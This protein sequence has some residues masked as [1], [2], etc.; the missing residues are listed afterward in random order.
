MIASC[1]FGVEVQ[2]AR[3][4][5]ACCLWRLAT[6]D[7]RQLQADAVISAIGMFN[8]IAVPD[9]EGLETFRGALFHTARWRDDHDL[10]GERV[11]IIG[12]AASAVQTIPEIAPVVARLD[13][14]QRTPQWVLPK[15]DEPRQRHPGGRRHRASRS[16]RDRRR[17]R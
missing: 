9:I 3:W 16:R 5:E 10:T 17:P 12:S 1:R 6:A 4:D 8:D 2:S 13:V 14:Y 7:G 11:A 15:A